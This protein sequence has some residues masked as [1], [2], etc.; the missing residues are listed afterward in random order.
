MPPVQRL[1]HA[2]YRPPSPIALTARCKH[3]TPS[4][5]A[6]HIPYATAQRGFGLHSV[7]DA[8]RR[9]NPPATLPLHPSIEQVPSSPS[10][11]LGKSASS[12]ELFV[13]SSTTSSVPMAGAEQEVPALLLDASL[14]SSMSYRRSIGVCAPSLPQ[15][16]RYSLSSR[17]PLP[18]P[19]P[20]LPCMAAHAIVTNEEAGRLT[21]RCCS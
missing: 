10:Q 8:Q 13:V 17:P 3:V 2:S 1:C 4:T 11:S 19:S 9:R 6:N 15:A 16:P 7:V 21:R 12:E 20:L 5:D 18:A 14:S